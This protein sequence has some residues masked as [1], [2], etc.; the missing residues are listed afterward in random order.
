VIGHGVGGK[1]ILKAFT[2]ERAESAEIL[3]GCVINYAD[4]LR[5]R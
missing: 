2:A 3:K 5:F 1:V 4:S